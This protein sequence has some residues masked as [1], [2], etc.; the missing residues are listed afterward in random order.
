VGEQISMGTGYGSTETGPTFCNI[1][2]PN[3]KT[4]LCGLPVP[5]SFA[6]LAPEGEKYEIRAKG[7][8]V[9]PGYYNPPDGAPSPFDEEGYYKLGDAAKLADRREPKAGLVF[10][11]R[12]VENFKLASGTFVAAGALR[13]QALSAIGGAASDAIVCGEAQS[14]VGLLLFPNDP[15]VRALGGLAAA[16]AAVAEGLARLNAAAAGS[17]GKIARA[18]MLQAPPDPLTGEITDKGYIN[19][20]LARAR[21]PAELARLFAPTPDDE[22]IVLD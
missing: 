11:G 3:V 20:A 5:G 8:Q 12:L 17:G 13:L 14:G 18:L 16:R 2:W 22:V 6:K 10:D 19:Q 7:P 4:G 15:E 1:H 9:S 21:R